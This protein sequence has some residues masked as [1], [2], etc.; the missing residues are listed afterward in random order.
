MKVSF[1]T[2]KRDLKSIAETRANE[3][4]ESDE[5]KID[6]SLVLDKYEIGQLIGTGAYGKFGEK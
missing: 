6:E 3:N 2:L 4:P 5:L 1:S